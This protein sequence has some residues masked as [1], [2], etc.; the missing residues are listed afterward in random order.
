MANGFAG[1]ND[2][3]KSL[4]S[5]RAT[6][7]PPPI[8]TMFPSLTPTNRLTNH[9]SPSTEPIRI[10]YFPINPIPVTV[11]MR[12][13][14]ELV[15]TLETIEGPMKPTPANATD[16]IGGIDNPNGFR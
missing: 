12:E 14:T 4:T 7:T 13:G 10:T 1:N 5:V 8:K 9:E 15:S 6:L 11:V 2:G 16:F 3:A